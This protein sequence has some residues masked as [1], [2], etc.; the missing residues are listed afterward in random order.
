MKTLA[1]KWTLRDNGIVGT[2]ESVIDRWQV[3]REKY[4]L[5]GS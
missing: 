4:G 2:P 5:K 3:R 1:T